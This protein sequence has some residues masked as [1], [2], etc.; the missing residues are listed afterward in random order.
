MVVMALKLSIQ[1]VK[2]RFISKSFMCTQTPPAGQNLSTTSYSLLVFL[3]QCHHGNNHDDV[4]V[5]GSIAISISCVWLVF[6]NKAGVDF[7]QNYSNMFH[8]LQEYYV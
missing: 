4:C 3:Q 7:D 1:L 2:N 6:D 8:Y 5:C